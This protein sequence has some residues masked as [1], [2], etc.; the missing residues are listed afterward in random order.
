MDFQKGYGSKGSCD[1]HSLII[2]LTSQLVNQ[3]DKKKK[4]LNF[5]HEALEDL[6]IAAF[7]LAL[8]S[9]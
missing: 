2:S 6:W 8:Q 9:Q 4:N 7:A 1:K 5:I 3:Y